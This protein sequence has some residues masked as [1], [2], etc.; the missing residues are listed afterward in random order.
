MPQLH[1]VLSMKIYLK[2]RIMK[3]KVLALTFGLIFFT[4]IAATSFAQVVSTTTNITVVDDDDDK[5][6]N[7]KKATTKTKEC[8][9]VGDKSCKTAKKSCCSSKMLKD[10]SCKDKKSD[11]ETKSEGDK[12]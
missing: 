10:D 3:F 7:K 9:D 1:L 6:K 4:S 12:R 2:K 5:D 8:K 11:K